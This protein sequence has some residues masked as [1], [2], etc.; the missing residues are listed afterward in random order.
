[1]TTDH[2]S[3]PTIQTGI[4]GLDKVLDGGLIPNRLYLVEG[5]PGSGKTTLALQFLREGVRRGEA[6]LFVTLSESKIEL[7]TSAESHG[8]NLDGIHIL[9][10][11]ASEHSL[12]PDTRYT[13]YHPSE[14]E[15][16]ETI[17]TVLTEAERI[18]P[19]RLV[20]DSLSELR[21]LAENPL[22]YRRQILAFKQYF[23][24]RQSTVFLIDDK[25]SAERD[26]HLH[27]L[28]HGVISLDRPAV[29][30]GTLRRR[31]RVR[32]LRGLAFREGYHDFVIRRGGIE[33]FPRLVAAEHRITYTRQDIK[34]G[35]AELDMLVGG[36]LARGTS[37]LIMGAAGTGKSSLATQYAREAAL[38]GEHA[39]IYL[40][41]EAIATF[42]ERSAG[43]GMDI[44]SLVKTGRITIQQVD[45]AELAPGEFA[46]TVRRA[47]EHDKAT[48]VVID[49]LNGY[50]NAMPSD[51]Y[52]TLHMH[53]LLTYLGQQGVTTLLLMAQNGIIGD[54]RAPVDASYLADTVLLLRYFEAYGEIRRAISVIK[55]RTGRHERAI[56]ELSLDDGFMVGEPLREFQGVLSG[57]PTY[58]GHQPRHCAEQE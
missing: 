23:S 4:S 29:E 45:P 37:T 10:I 48:I 52:L 1:M 22:R 26:M 56:R 3:N 58:L 39:A 13:M 55:K 40:F 24:R 41:D 31:L 35:V 54:M 15:L 11:M 57:L 47:V 17:K 30:Y 27:S 33:L 7:Q 43:L 25:T 50:L 14:V 21:L 36:G 32:K 19:A 28:A 2:V 34:S 53:E 49:S 18:K 16:G 46:H 12:A 5:E 51:R 44:E 42:L 8:W 9:E 38:R 20:F 6:C